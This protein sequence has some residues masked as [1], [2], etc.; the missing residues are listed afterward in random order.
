[1]TNCDMVYC[2]I[3]YLKLR[4]RGVCLS[5]LLTLLLQIRPKYAWSHF[6]CH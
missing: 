3:A 4:I 2:T 1:M 5:H 6:N